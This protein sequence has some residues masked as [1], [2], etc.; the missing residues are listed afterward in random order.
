MA[1]QWASRGA[2]R[3]GWVR[4]VIICAIAVAVSLL[5]ATRLPGGTGSRDSLTAVVVALGVAVAVIVVIATVGRSRATA[6][7]EGLR[8]AMLRSARGPVSSRYD[9]FSGLTTATV[10]EARFGVPGEVRA[11]PDDGTA[12]VVYHVR[13][14]DDAWVMSVER[15][16]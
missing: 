16:A 3:R 5:A 15:G 12:F 1:R 11:M 2:A 14:G 4:A 10:G 6:R 13:I 9:A 8:G 7:A